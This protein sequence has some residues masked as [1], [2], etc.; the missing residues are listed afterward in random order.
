[1]RPAA[2]IICIGNRL[3]E[4]DEAGPRVFDRLRGGALPP[5]VALADG[6]LAGID[7][8]RLVEGLERVVFV[9]SVA[10]FG[11]PG[12]V[13][14]LSVAEVAAQAEGGF[15]HGA[16]LPYLLRM[17]PVVLDGALPEVAVVGLEGPAGEGAVEI[18]ARTSL[19]L[20]AGGEAMPD[21]SPRGCP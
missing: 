14:V 11:P 16:G 6:G 13:V 5:T 7:L 1:M 21:S 10:G 8:A 20:A 17:L 18:A 9:D 2:R 15:G 3:A 19:A 12:A 4:E